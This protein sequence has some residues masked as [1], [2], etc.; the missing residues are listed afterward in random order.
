VILSDLALAAHFLRAGS[1]AGAV[2]CVAALF[3][4]LIRKAWAARLVQI[5][6][7]A[8]SVEWVRTMVLLARERQR[9]GEPWLRMALIL[10]AVALFTAASALVFSSERVRRHYSLRARSERAIATPERIG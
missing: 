10:L 4:L 3:L 9:L 6:L 1:L 2:G 7:L 8:G 5:V